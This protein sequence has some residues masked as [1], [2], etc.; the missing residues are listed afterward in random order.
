MHGFKSALCYFQVHI[1]VNDTNDNRPRFDREAYVLSISEAT[2]VGTEI[3]A[4]GV[5]DLDLFDEHIYTM[6]ANSSK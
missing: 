5:N 3:I 2:P 1:Y 4:L 6:E